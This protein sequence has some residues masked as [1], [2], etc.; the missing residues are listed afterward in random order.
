MIPTLLGISLL[1]FIIIQLPPGDYLTTYMAELEAQGEA[2]DEKIEFL[3]QTYGLDQPMWKQYLV[4]VGGLLRGDFGQSFEFNLPAAQIIGDQLLLTFI[5]SF[6]TIVFTYLVAFPIGIYSATHQYSTSDYTLTFLGFL[7][8]A[9]P[10]FL[11]ALVLLYAANVW[12]GT[13]IGGLMDPEYLDRPMSWGKFVSI[14]EHLW[15]PVLVIGTSGTAGLIRRL[16]ANLLDEMQKQY[17]VTARAKG[18]PPLRALFKYPLRMALNPFI[19]DIGNLLPQVISGAAIVSVVLSLPTTGPMLLN[20]LRTQDMYLAG[21]FLM[22][23]AFLTV[24][25]VLVSDLALALLDPRIRLGGG[26]SR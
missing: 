8:L 19:A 6:A 22:C 16:R 3:R 24:L 11:L 5:V 20:A 12:F 21:S 17:V 7:G 14:L 2:A 9:T 1:T 4:W 15:V 13:S 26:A 23:L 18:M 25:G 10:N